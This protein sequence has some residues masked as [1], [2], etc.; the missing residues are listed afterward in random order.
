MTLGLRWIT[1]DSF[2]VRRDTFNCRMIALEDVGD[3][4]DS[5]GIRG[6]T[7]YDTK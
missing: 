5:F 1:E 7:L 2:G 4:L 3:T 6:I